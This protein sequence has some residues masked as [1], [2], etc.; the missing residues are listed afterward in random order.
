M[1]HNRSYVSYFKVSDLYSVYLVYPASIIGDNKWFNYATLAVAVD[2]SGMEDGPLD[3]PHP[4][5][6]GVAQ[7]GGTTG[8]HNLG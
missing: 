5:G 3:N 1:S 7:P 4:Y 8:W 2:C 6:F